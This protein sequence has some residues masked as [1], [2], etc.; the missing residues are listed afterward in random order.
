LPPNNGYI[1][2]KININDTAITTTIAS[3]T[4][5]SNK[6]GDFKTDITFEHLLIKAIQII[7]NKDTLASSR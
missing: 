6:Y 7:G 3:S 5:Q 2:L 1:V 4:N